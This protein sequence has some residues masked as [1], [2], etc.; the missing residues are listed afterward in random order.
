MSFQFQK[1]LFL[2]PT[3]QQYGGNMVMTNVIKPKKK[4]YLNIDT[5]YRDDSSVYTSNTVANFNLTLTERLTDVREICVRNVELPMTIYNI[6]TE[7]GNNYFKI[8]DLSNNV[9]Q[10]VEITPGE[11]NETT[12]A[13]EINNKI[14]TLGGW[15]SW[16]EMGFQ[17]HFARFYIPSATPRTFSLDFSV[18]RDGTHDRF[19]FKRKMGWLLGYRLPSYVVKYEVGGYI[20]SENMA[21]LTGLRYVY[22][23][24]DEFNNMKQNTFNSMLPR[25]LVNK[26]IIAKISFNKKTYDFTSVLPANTF[27]GYLL[28]D[29]RNYGENGKADI[30]K[31][32]IQ[33]VDDIGNPVSMNGQDFSFCLEV[34]HE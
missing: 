19:H 33:V 14:N 6:S 8:T 1:E 29:T 27:N 10:M 9:S 28:S 4:K 12:L 22:L 32:N 34:I 31:L 16:V 24:L 7:I 17:S 15:F 5:K 21:D 2:E 20:Q 13:A 23:V 11:Y 30:Q 26:N 3:V 25:S 18:G